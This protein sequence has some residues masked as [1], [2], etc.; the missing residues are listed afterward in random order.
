MII[1]NTQEMQLFKEKAAQKIKTG[2]LDKNK[3][4]FGKKWFDAQTKEDIAAMYVM[5]K[6]KD[7][8]D[9]CEPFRVCPECNYGHVFFSEDAFSCTVCSTSW[10]LQ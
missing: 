8:K 4:K 6:K 2:F 5:M 1:S 9:D 3:A 7:W 10:G